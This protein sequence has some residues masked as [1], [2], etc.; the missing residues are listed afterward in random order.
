MK[1]VTCP[2]VVMEFAKL[3]RRN[4]GKIKLKDRNSEIQVFE[5]QTMSQESPQVNNVPLS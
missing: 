5:V 4:V 3:R 1:E 2:R